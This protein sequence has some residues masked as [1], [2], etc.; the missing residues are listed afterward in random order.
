MD[1]FR[2]SIGTWAFGAVPDRYMAGGY[3]DKPSLEGQIDLASNVAGCS[4]VE[5]S[6][7]PGAVTPETASGYARFAADRGLAVSALA[8]NVTGDRRWAQGSLT[9]PD[10][11]A[12]AEAL[13]RIVDCLECAR[14]MDVGLVNLWMGQD[15]FDYPFEADYARLW[16]DLVSGLRECAGAVPEVLLSVEYKAKE[17]RVRNIPNSASQT[18]LAVAAA[19]SPNLRVTLDFGHAILGGENASQ[20]AAMLASYGRLGHI[21]MNDNSGDWDWDMASGVSHW[22][23]LV[24][25]CLW[26][27][28]LSYPGWLSLD[29]FPYRVDPAAA[30]ALCIKATEKARRLAGQLKARGVDEALARRD[31]M[32]VFGALMDM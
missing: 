14:A 9:N 29:I 20:S 5:L 6:F 7:A 31:A 15:G 3:R 26:L 32:A 2:Y 13:A 11:A 19:A 24:E 12:R 10:R 18:L 8:V 25:F 28:R 1:T 27:D 22:W 16:E 21:H 4:G 17:P 30:C 23:E